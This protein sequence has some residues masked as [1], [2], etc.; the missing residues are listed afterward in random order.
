MKIW[1]SAKFHISLCYYC[2]SS[3]NI[4]LWFDSAFN[5]EGQLFKCIK[6]LSFP[7]LT[8]HRTKAAK[9]KPVNPCGSW[10]KSGFDFTDSQLIAKKGCPC[11]STWAMF[12]SVLCSPRVEQRTD[13]GPRPWRRRVDFPSS[14]NDFPSTFPATFSRSATAFRSLFLSWKLS[15]R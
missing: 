15:S 3:S 2:I 11:L 13:T 9:C 14:S 12:N 4:L 10:D 8:S 1:W 6:T 5:I 7:T